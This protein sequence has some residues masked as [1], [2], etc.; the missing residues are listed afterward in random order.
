MLSID[1]Y[2]N[3]ISLF[4]IDV[5]LR[6]WM[7][8]TPKIIF[9]LKLL[10]ILSRSDIKDSVDNHFWTNFSSHVKKKSNICFIIFKRSELSNQGS[11][12]CKFCNQG[13]IGCKFCNQRNIGCKFCNQRNIGCKFCNQGN[14]GCKFVIKVASGEGKIG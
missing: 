11:I 2:L 12:R 5:K 7:I 10:L 13:N 4:I 8:V 9:R 3:F 6:K 14:I 1:H